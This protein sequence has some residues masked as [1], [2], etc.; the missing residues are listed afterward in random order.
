[1]KR[2]PLAILL[3]AVALSVSGCWF[4]PHGLESIFNPHPAPGS[5]TNT[6]HTPKP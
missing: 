3:A 1:M 6:T 5:A 4:G 2:L